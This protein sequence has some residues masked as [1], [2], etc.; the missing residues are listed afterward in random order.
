M[1]HISRELPHLNIS[2]G[3][4]TGMN[5]KR[6]FIAIIAA[7]CLAIAGF[8]T[9]MPI[10]PYYLQ[11]LGLTA[12]TGLNFWNG[13]IQ[14]SAAVALAIFAPIWGSLADH[15]G[16]KKMLLRAMLGGG[17]II[18]LMA[19]VTEP[20]QLWI[21]RMLQGTVTGTVAA[22]TVLVSSIVPENKIGFSLGLLQTSVYVGNS[23]GPLW[24]GMISDAFG[25]RVNFLTTSGMLFLAAFIVVFF[26]KDNFVPKPVKGNVLRNAVPDFSFVMSQSTIVPLLMIIFTIQTA[27]S[28]INPILPLYIQQIT[29]AAVLLGTT[30][31]MILGAGAVSSAT[32]SALMGRVSDRLG[33]KRTLIVSLAGAVLLYI[34]QGL[35]T[36]WQQLLVLRIADGMFLGGTIP[37]VNAMLSARTPVEK[38]GSVFG[39][40]SSAASTGA[41][42]GPALGA[43]A[44][45]TMG[46]RS[47]FF[48][49]SALVAISGLNIFVRSRRTA[50]GRI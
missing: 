33:Y 18:G 30:T 7:E 35:V 9:S 29:P 17:V 50:P 19:F 43:L 15:Y 44:A 39:I 45:S 31:G 42:L 14:A 49:T 36:S 2:P 21:L 38:R 25:H 37:A 1:Y 4:I 47:V 13:L 32:S 24:G 40:S 12:E 16:R 41:A 3:L 23:I 22:A 28:V 20:W 8:A 10:I 34:P 11:E 27:H 48:V 6:T 26:V 5:W 46:Y